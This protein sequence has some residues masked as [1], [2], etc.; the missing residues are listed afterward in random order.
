MKT[1]STSADI[2]K[3]VNSFLKQ[4]DW[5]YIEPGK[6]H[7]KVRSRQTQDFIPVPFS[8]SDYRAVKALR[9]QLQRLADTGHGLI[10]A[11]GNPLSA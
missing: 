2:R 1:I 9:A 11:R 5:L 3:L 6:R 7:Y 4:F 8:P 10:Y